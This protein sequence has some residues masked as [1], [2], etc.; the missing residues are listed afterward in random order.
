VAQTFKPPATQR[1]YDVCVV[2]SQLG[3]VVAGALLAR[4]GFRVLHVDHDG[5]GGSYVEHGYVLPWGPAMLPSPRQLPAAELVLAE[6]GL[7]TDVGRLLEPSEPDLQILLPKHRIDLGRDA[8]V[9]RQELRREW[10]VDAD[11]LEAAM[12]DLGKLF[13]VAGFFLKQAPPLPP[14]GFGE[15]RT[16]KKAIKLA[17]NAPGAP[18]EPV[19]EA[20][21]FRGFEDHELVR[22]LAVAHRFLTYLDGEPSPLSAVRLLG[23]ALRG[24]H[25]LAGGLGT[26]RELIRKRIAESRGELRGGA[27]EPVRASAFDLDGSRVT[28]VRLEDSPDAYVARAYVAATDA[29]VFRTLLPAEFTASKAGRFLGEVRPSRIL[30]SLN[31]VVKRGALPPALGENVFAL[32]DPAGGDGI[33]N[34]VFLQ[35]L[36]ARRE[37]GKKSPGELVADERVV[38]A[39]AFIPATDTSRAA[40]TAAAARVR[41]AVA[42]A[43]P[44]FERHLLSESIPMLAGPEGRPPVHPLYQ[45]ELDSTLGVTGLPVRGPFKN[46]FFAGREV[47]PGLG[48]E[49]EFYAGIEAAGHV[50]AALGRKELL[51]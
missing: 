47:L 17:S 8:A 37:A 39:S 16:V 25:R 43:I 6:L 19:G 12:G 50:A 21:A 26:L 9:L 34:A 18:A 45:V 24:T 44:F 5:L 27:G 10:P 31:L 7:A 46:L 20:R 33:D 40:L 35:V 15:R 2:G 51:K 1:I 30:L 48:V 36:P 13:E 42:D 14:D 29:A 11:R 4:R 22:S 3:G 23:G 28:A 41:E 38:C 49:G 32:R